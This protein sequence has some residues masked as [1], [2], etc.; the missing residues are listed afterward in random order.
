[1]ALPLPVATTPLRKGIRIEIKRY[2][3]VRSMI[4]FN[5]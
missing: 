2:S 5:G 3:G 4:I 1:M